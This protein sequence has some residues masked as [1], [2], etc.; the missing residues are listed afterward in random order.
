M[1]PCP[2]AYSIAQGKRPPLFCKQD[3]DYESEAYLVQ[4]Q[5][6]VQRLQLREERRSEDSEDR[7]L[8][9]AGKASATYRGP[10]G[11]DDPPSDR[12]RS[13]HALHTLKTPKLRCSRAEVCSRQ[14][15]ERPTSS[16]PE[17][18]R[19][20]PLRRSAIYRRFSPHDKGIGETGRFHNDGYFYCDVDVPVGTI[21]GP[22]I[23][24]STD[25]LVRKDP[26]RAV[27]GSARRIT[28]PQVHSESPG[29]AQYGSSSTLRKS[30]YSFSK[31]EKSPGPRV[32]VRSDSPGPGQYDLPP[33]FA[34]RPSYFS[35]S[36][37]KPH[38]GLLI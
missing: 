24:L 15:R 37:A 18:H 13:S 4:K 14:C 8:A 1:F 7:L 19:D 20:S 23:Y 27:F 3:S 22:G 34:N 32:S 12:A 28:L 35:K 36:R 11:E 38:Y 31:A 33:A 30:T 9:T 5:P 10:L 25:S 6:R 2:P 26:P 16:G 17:K 29:P 21:Q